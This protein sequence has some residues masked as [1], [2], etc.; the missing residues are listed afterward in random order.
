MKFVF[1]S[2]VCYLIPLSVANII[3][4]IISKE[5]DNLLPPKSNDEPVLV[6]ITLSLL[7]LRSVKA[8]DLTFTVD[9]FVHQY[10]TDNR[11]TY[12]S[13]DVKENSVTLHSSWSNKLWI[14]D[15]YFKN[16]ISG[17][18][19]AQQF[20]TT[21]FILHSN[22]TIFMASR[23]TVQL[24]C[25]MDFTQYPHDSHLCSIKVTSLSDQRSTVEL[26]WS[27]FIMSKR[28]HHTDYLIEFVSKDRCDKSYVIVLR[29]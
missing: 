22:K 8:Q 19:S 3:A 2:I 17:E 16:G 15:I 10:W 9:L 21:Y 4:D 12:P 11:L 24:V 28:L 7:N 13:S 6:N 27:D 5:Y 29:L 1:I 14:P 26:D 18:I 23:V 20:K 25:D